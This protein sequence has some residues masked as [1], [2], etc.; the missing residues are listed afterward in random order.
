MDGFA[1][2]LNLTKVEPPV[3]FQLAQDLT[4]D[5]A[6]PE[7]IA[8]IKPKLDLL[9]TKHGAGVDFYEKDYQPIASETQPGL[10]NWET[11]DLDPH[12]FRYHVIN[13]KNSNYWLHQL[14]SAAILSK[15]E[16][17]LGPE[18]HYE[19]GHQMGWGHNTQRHPQI[20]AA[21]VPTLKDEDFISAT[22]EQ[23]EDLTTIYQKFVDVHGTSPKLISA[24][25][26][27]ISLQ[28][29][30]RSS[31]F[32]IIGLFTIL[33]GAIT[34]KPKPNDPYESI[35]RQ[36]KQKVALLNN[37][38]DTKLG[39]SHHFG[40]TMA[41]EKVWEKLYAC[42]S[43]I[44]HGGSPDYAKELSVLRNH[45]NVV[46]FLRQVVRSVLRQMLLEPQLIADLYE[47]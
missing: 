10:T 43:T 12:E 36:I 25:G 4:L 40:N 19:N 13:Y 38:F 39:Y 42:R 30:A 3:P 7:Q 16:M 8:E 23:L 28:G 1:I 14:E 29:I 45:R 27:Y 21:L 33:E 15:V 22:K 5:K 24:I 47:C 44:A 37:R 2:V 31:K 46:R 11:R 18:V 17:I 6:T 9:L 26:E 34:H 41:P 35:T 32:Q 20:I